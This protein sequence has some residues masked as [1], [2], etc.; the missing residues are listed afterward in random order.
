MM[1]DGGA[2]F[3]GPAAAGTI[4]LAQRLPSSSR[5]CSL[6]RACEVSLL[7]RLPLMAHH[8]DN[9]AGVVNGVD[10]DNEVAICL[11]TP[12]GTADLSP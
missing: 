1:G 10:S 2:E 12:L 8:D 3:G 7:P 9:Q 6:A 4:A 11:T 5:A